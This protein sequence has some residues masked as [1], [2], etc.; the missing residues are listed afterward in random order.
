[1]SPD[2][3]SIAAARAKE[4]R[5]ELVLKGD[6]TVRRT[7]DGGRSLPIHP[8]YMADALLNGAP[9]SATAGVP[10]HGCSVF[11]EGDPIAPGSTREVELEPRHPSSWGEVSVAD[12]LGL[13]E[14]LRRIATF[15]VRR[16]LPATVLRAW[17]AAEAAAVPDAGEVEASVSKLQEAVQR[18]IAPEPSRDTHRS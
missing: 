14:G 5:R 18:Y 6:L 8:K 9:D 11:F 15:T 12:Q 10:V 4:L 16:A 17:E 7:E 13:Y 1:M 2:T 3:H